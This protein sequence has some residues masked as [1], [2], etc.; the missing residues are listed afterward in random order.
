MCALMNIHLLIYYHVYSQNCRANYILHQI[1]R[2]VSFAL[3]GNV[4]EGTTFKRE[5]LQR[6]CLMLNVLETKCLSWPGV[7]RGRWKAQQRN[8]DSYNTN[9]LQITVIWV[10]WSAL[11]MRERRKIVSRSRSSKLQ[12]N[13]NHG[14]FQLPG[15]WLLHPAWLFRTSYNIYSLPNRNWLKLI[16]QRNPLAFLANFFGTV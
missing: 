8:T 15:A 1:P 4:P 9:V 3:F 13:I 7:G 10:K 16:D 6:G 14:S 12:L 5:R 2:G 11:E